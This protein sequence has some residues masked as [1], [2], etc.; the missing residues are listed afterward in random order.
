MA[1]ACDKDP[2][3][4]HGAGHISEDFEFQV[5]KRLDGNGIV[6][7]PTAL[8]LSQLGRLFFGSVL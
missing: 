4:L 1:P 7:R 5:R 2:S 6:V 3:V 8:A